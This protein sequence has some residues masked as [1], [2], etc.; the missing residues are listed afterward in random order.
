MYLLLA[1]VSVGMFVMLIGVSLA[2]LVTQHMRKKGDEEDKENADVTQPAIVPA[3]AFGDVEVGEKKDPVS[4]P[5]SLDPP[6]WLKR[7]SETMRQKIAGDSTVLSAELKISRSYG[8]TGDSKA[9]V[10]DTVALSTTMSEELHDTNCGKTFI[11]DDNTCQ[12]PAQPD[13]INCNCRIAATASYE[14]MNME[15][16]NAASESLTINTFPQNGDGKST[17]QNPQPFA[18][19][20]QTQTAG[21]Y[22]KQ[23]VSSTNTPSDELQA[24]TEY[25]SEHSTS[26]SEEDTVTVRE[27]NNN[28][29]SG[30]DRDEAEMATN[31]SHVGTEIS[32]AFATLSKDSGG[33][34]PEKRVSVQS[35]Q[36][37]RGSNSSITAGEFGPSQQD[38][39][40]GRGSASTLLSSASN[41]E[42]EEKYIPFNPVTELPNDHSYGEVLSSASV[43]TWSQYTI[44]EEDPSIVTSPSMV[45]DAG[46]AAASTLVDSGLTGHSNGAVHLTHPTQLSCF[47]PSSTSAWCGSAERGSPQVQ[48][49]HTH[50][51]TQH[52]PQGRPQPTP[53]NTDDLS[54]PR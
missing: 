30:E 47:S 31:I 37:G 42:M 44:H 32:I 52:T 25:F 53:S 20:L 18:D 33:N 50:T 4:N 27:N 43:V 17:D 34:T 7:N 48:H 1:L 12:Q 51:T 45:D 14:V 49:T 46:A 8:S 26:A 19:T 29:T 15:P 16:K 39:R 38:Y 5:P 22:K 28:S 2:T 3:A 21:D 36:N 11:D 23:P 10:K 41:F 54:G 24:G 13:Q 6:N 40:D 35:S 9:M